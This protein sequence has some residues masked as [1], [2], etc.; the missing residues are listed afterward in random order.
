ML[1]KI[2][3]FFQNLWSSFVTKRAEKRLTKELEQEV[4]WY[5][6]AGSDIRPKIEMKQTQEKY[7]QGLFHVKEALKKEVEACG[8]DWN[9]A[10]R[11]VDLIDLG[12][13]EDSDQKRFRQMRE[14]MYHYRGADVKSDK[15][16]GA[17]IDR[18][19]ADYKKLQDKVEERQLL[20]KIRMF[21]RS[22]DI[23]EANRLEQE[24][25][26]KYGKTRSR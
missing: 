9:Q 7:A 20:R 21:R 19:I 15:D 2:S 4:D 5:F 17:M 3:S 8:G 25:K 1:T 12:R 22:G 6:N 23:Q 16:K 26:D 14:S 11:N 13:K 24:W 10:L 18:R